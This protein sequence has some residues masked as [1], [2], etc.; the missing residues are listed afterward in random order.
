LAAERFL[1]D[2]AAWFALKKTPATFSRL[3]H[4]RT[5]V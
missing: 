1:G 5:A 4:E 2:S 3:A